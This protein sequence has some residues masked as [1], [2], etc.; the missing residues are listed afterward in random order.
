MKR[1]SF[2]IVLMTLL[3]LITGCSDGKNTAAYDL[4]GKTYYN[5]IDEYGNTDHSQIWFGKDGSFVMKDNFAEGYYE[6]TGTWSIKENV[7]TLDVSSSGVGNY[8]TI[9]F[10]IQDNDTIVLKSSLAGS[11]SN[12]YFT[13]AEIKGEPITFGTYYNYSQNEGDLDYIEIKAD[14]SFMLVN[15]YSEPITETK[16]TWA[17]KD[18]MLTMTYYKDGMENIFEMEIKD[19]KNLVLLNDMGPSATGD[20]FSIDPPV[21]DIP[22]PVVIPCTGLKASE[23]S[24]KVPVNSSPFYLGIQVLPSDCTEQIYFTS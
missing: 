23:T 2:L 8:K 16:G 7:C 21:E 11:R 1:S 13:T 14:G 10:E 6:I 17:L 12:S 18:K 9:L 3:L 4:A 19:P 24:Y 15:R 22:D 5:T 20:I